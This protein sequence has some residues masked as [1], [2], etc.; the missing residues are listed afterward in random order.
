MRRLYSSVRGLIDRS[1]ANDLLICLPFVLYY[2]SHG[3]A[4][5]NSS[6][7]TAKFVKPL[8]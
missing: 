8:A 7:Q 4:L 3:N 5:G 2:F 6:L 1:G